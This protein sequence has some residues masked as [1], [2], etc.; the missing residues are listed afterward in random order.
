MKKHVVFVVGS[1][2]KY[3]SPGANIASKVWAELQKDRDL[4][5]TI[6]T[7]KEHY[8][9]VV[10]GNEN[11]IQIVDKATC[12]HHKCQEKLQTAKHVKRVYYKLLLK[13]KRALHF[14]AMLVRRNGYSSKMKRKT[15]SALKKLHKRKPI[16]ILIPIG[17]PH[18][19]MFAGLKFKKKNLSIKLLPYQLDRY[20][21]G[22]SLYK[23]PKLQKGL[24]K[25]NLKSERQLIIYSEALFVLCPIYPHYQQEYFND[26]L[27]KVI[28]TEHPLIVDH[29]KVDIKKKN[30]NSDNAVVITYAGSLDKKL[31]NPTEWFQVLV[32]LKANSAINLKNKLY[33]FGNCGDIIAT[34]KETLGKTLFDGGK[35]PYAKVIE[36]YQNSNF[37]LTIGNRS[38]EEVP[39]KVFD[40]MSFGKPIIHLY[41]FEEDPCL[42]YLKKY[43]M[44][45]C[46]PIEQGKIKD[47]A[48]A[49][50]KFIEQYNG[51]KIEFDQIEKLFEDCTPA[52]VAR[53]FYQKF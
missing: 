5:L 29:A 12:L 28:P 50:E 15:F 11:V 49:L 6:I 32:Q 16:D 22:L 27:D 17:E 40:C 25:R 2:G 41:F 46:L 35:I 44:T 1:Y 37:I 51:Q 9:D 24:K 42:R 14:V 30:D 26:L 20:A 10:D 45:L 21:N 38:K 8:D 52:F 18:D 53:L 3:M 23:F 33:S 34:Y 47:N 31:R 43:P 7:R 39:S 36:E 19:A 48:V 13:A 4:E